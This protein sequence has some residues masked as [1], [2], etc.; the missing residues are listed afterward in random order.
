[1]KKQIQTSATGFTN[2]SGTAA[3][4]M[5]RLKADGMLSPHLAPSLVDQVNNSLMNAQE[6]LCGTISGGT[7]TC[8]LGC[9]EGTHCYI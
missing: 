7:Q 8:I 1:M 2:L 3:G 6:H 5:L 4:W 9:M